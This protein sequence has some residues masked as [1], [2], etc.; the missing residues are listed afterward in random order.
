MHIND[1]AEFNQQ[2]S[3]HLIDKY[4]RNGNIFG[5][6]ISGDEFLTQKVRKI[7]LMNC[8]KIVDS[9]YCTACHTCL[10]AETFY[11]FSDILGTDC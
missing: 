8:F 3:K 10:S 5:P 7:F 4:P 11:K 1:C 2:F 6:K 9:N